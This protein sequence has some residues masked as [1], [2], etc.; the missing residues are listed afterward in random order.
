MTKII[1]NRY[2]I[3]KLGIVILSAVWW[4]NYKIWTQNKEVIKFYQTL[5][6]FCS[7]SVIHTYICA[8]PIFGYGFK[9]QSSYTY[10]ANWIALCTVVRKLLIHTYLRQEIHNINLRCQSAERWLTWKD[11]IYVDFLVIIFLKRI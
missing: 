10:Q 2:W 3:S 4:Q 5:K 9:V 11:K 1:P 6:C 8:S 7:V